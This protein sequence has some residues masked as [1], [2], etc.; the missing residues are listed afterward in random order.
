VQS[1]P[2][3]DASMRDS[4]RQWSLRPETAGRRGHFGNARTAG[5]ASAVVSA[6]IE[7]RAP[8]KDEPAQDGDGGKCR[9]NRVSQQQGGGDGAA[10]GDEVR[11]NVVDGGDE[12]LVEDVGDSNEETAREGHGQEN[13]HHGRS[14][15][16]A[17]ARSGDRRRLRHVGS[18]KLGVMTRGGHRTRHIR[19]MW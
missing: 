10:E 2:V 11:G 5:R 15:A 13:A 19:R 17:C 18:C 14:L 1:L 12:P 8:R 4:A 16:Q 6:A 7:D 9:G 3:S